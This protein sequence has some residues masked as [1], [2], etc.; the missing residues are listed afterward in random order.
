[1]SSTG[2]L[3][4]IVFAF[5]FVLAVVVPIVGGILQFGRQYLRVMR[6]PLTGFEVD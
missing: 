5:F 4:S 6:D 2:M 3:V 1:M